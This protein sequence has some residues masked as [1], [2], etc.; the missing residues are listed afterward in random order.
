[1]CVFN[2]SLAQFDRFSQ[3]IVVIIN[4]LTEL[5]CIRLFQG[6]YSGNKKFSQKFSLFQGF[7]F[8]V[9]WVIWS[10]DQAVGNTFSWF[11]LRYL[12]VV[13]RHDHFLVIQTALIYLYTL[14][15]EVWKSTSLLYKQ[16]L[17][18]STLSLSVEVRKSDWQMLPV[19]LVS[20][21]QHHVSF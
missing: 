10:K 5:G 14:S 16:L 18:T 2:Q 9:F 7:I 1:M 15:I 4:I 17:S 8:R 11:C 20:F 21:W 3:P 6:N 12:S 13:T 19:R